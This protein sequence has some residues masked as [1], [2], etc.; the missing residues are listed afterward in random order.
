M[1]RIITQPPVERTERAEAQP[2]WRRLGLLWRADFFSP[3]DFVRRAL[4]IS[5]IYLI[6]SFTNLKEFT[7]VLNGTMGS[8]EIGWWS[9]AFLGIAGVLIYLAFVLLAPMLLLAAAFLAIWKRFAKRKQF[10][11]EVL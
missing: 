6:A 4:M 7:T 3:K 8:V 10:P 1:N 5:V 2:V 11:D 9:S